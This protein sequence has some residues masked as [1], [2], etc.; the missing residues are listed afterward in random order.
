[1]F[2]LKKVQNKKEGFK[3]IFTMRK[4]LF[5]L[6]VQNKEDMLFILK[7]QNKEDI[8]CCDTPLI[9][10]ETKSLQVPSRLDVQGRHI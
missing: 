7:D 5:I 1:M 8:L 3:G 6:K 10:K 9:Q 2:T 4:M